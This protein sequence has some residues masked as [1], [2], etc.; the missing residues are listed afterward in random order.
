MA[1]TR[2]DLE[3]VGQSNDIQD[4]KTLIDTVVNAT[5]K[6]GVYAKKLDVNEKLIENIKADFVKV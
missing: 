1:I 6:L 2:E 5:D 3:I 4:Y